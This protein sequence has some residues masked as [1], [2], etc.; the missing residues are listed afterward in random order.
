M[1]HKL[2]EFIGQ[3]QPLEPYNAPTET[4]GGPAGPAVGVAR[5]AG[6]PAELA[7]VF[8]ELSGVHAVPTKALAVLAQ[9]YAEAI[10]APRGVREAIAAVTVSTVGVARGAGVPAELA[11]VF[12]ELSRVH[13]VPGKA[14]A[15]LGEVYAEAIGAPRGVREA[16]AAA[17]VAG[18]EAVVATAAARPPPKH[19]LRTSGNLQPAAVI[20]RST[21]SEAAITPPTFLRTH[22][23]IRNETLS[24]GGGCLFK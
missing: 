18:S 13:A 5:G 9:V 3:V 14:L 16:V 1:V 19:R 10:E 22:S 23:R 6:V 17:M 7:E 12:S 20:E 2:T 4:S 24:R 8:A 15:H 11:E 21:R